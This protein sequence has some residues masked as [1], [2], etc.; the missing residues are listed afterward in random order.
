MT[1]LYLISFYPLLSSCQVVGVF[2]GIEF[3]M[4]QAEVKILL[5]E[6]SMQVIEINL[7]SPEFPLAKDHEGHLI[8]ENVESAKGLIQK[9][10]FTFAD[11]KLCYIEARGNAVK[12]L[13]YSRSDT[14]KTYLDYKVYFSDLLF[15]NVQKDIVWMLTE[16]SLHPNLFTW[17]NPYISSG[18]LVDRDYIKSAKIPEFVV[19]GASLEELKPQFEAKSLMISEEIL[20]DSDPNAQLQINA[21]GIEYAGFPRKFEA[22]F[23][24][25]K[26][27]MV[28]VLTGKGEENRIREKLI[29]AYGQAIF[30]DDAWEAFHGWQIMLRKDKPEV[31]FMTKE[32]AKY[33]KV[34]YFGQ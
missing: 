30:S 15:A 32:L 9:V 28:W 26:L 4:T 7:D 13:I 14:A 24:D 18:T 29:E 16:E 34:Q 10:G 8:G 2:N 12:G 22:R 31:L 11:D 27:N 19:M 17:E 1:L 3:G 21:F 23:G 33:Y 6:I 5:S 20:D 25:N